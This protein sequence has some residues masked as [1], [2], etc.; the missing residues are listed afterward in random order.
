MNNIN[1]DLLHAWIYSS[2]IDLLCNLSL[3]TKLIT[4]INIHT[5][6]RLYATMNAMVL[7][8]YI[9]PYIRKHQLF[10]PLSSTH[11]YICIHLRTCISSLSMIALNSRD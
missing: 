5:F 4:I 9:T 3:L 6:E 2:R 1:T 7:A 8:Q 11:E 10:N